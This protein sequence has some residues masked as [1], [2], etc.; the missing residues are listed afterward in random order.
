MCAARANERDVVVYDIDSVLSYP[1]Q[2]GDYLQQSFP[3]QWPFP[4]APMFRLVPA[5]LYLQHFASDRL[6]MF[7]AEKQ[8]WNATPPTYAC[9]NVCDGAVSSN[10]QR[11]IDFSNKNDKESNDATIYGKVLSLSQ[12]AEYPDFFAQETMLS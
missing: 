5:M 1:M 4:Y 2:L 8:T 11:Y 10:F 12:L 9:I 7:N 3:Y 6:H